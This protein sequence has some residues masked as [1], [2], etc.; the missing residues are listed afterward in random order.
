M[1]YS[2]SRG[3]IE[4]GKNRICDICFSPIFDADGSTLVWQVNCSKLVHSAQMLLTAGKSLTVLNEAKE[5][6]SHSGR[7]RRSHFTP[8]DYHSKWISTRFFQLLDMR[9]NYNTEISVFCVHFLFPFLLDP[10]FEKSFSMYQ[11][12]TLSVT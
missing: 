5:R 8:R 6:L 7:I 10:F 9:Q 1:S 12:T 3:K 11:F 2:C 4:S